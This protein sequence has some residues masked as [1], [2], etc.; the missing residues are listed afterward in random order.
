[1]LQIQKRDRPEYRWENKET[2][3]SA[4][5]P[6]IVSCDNLTLYTYYLMIG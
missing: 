5:E 3:A 6:K 2:L 1:M 4:V